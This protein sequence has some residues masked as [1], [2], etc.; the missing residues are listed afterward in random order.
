MQLE[1]KRIHR[2]VG[3]TFLYVTHDQEEALVLSD[4]IAVMNC[5]RLE[6]LDSVEN[7]YLSPRSR[8]VSDFIGEINLFSGT[9]VA[10]TSS[11]MTL[12]TVEGD[13]LNVDVN[14]NLTVG[15]DVEAAV[16]PEK[17]YLSAEPPH[18]ENSFPGVVVDHAFLGP[19]IKYFVQLDSGKKITVLRQNQ[20][21][22]GE[23]LLRPGERL[24]LSWDRAWVKV[25]PRV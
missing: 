6:Q 25:F 16:R 22:P 21:A 19:A 24:T 11:G 23:R 4:R 3:I 10:S 2:E 7:I 9:L 17:I 15:N 14:A 12:L 8:Y 18:G 5:G 20:G 13:A 1:L